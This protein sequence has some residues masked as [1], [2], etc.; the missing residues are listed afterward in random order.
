MTLSE[1]W[2]YLE[3]LMEQI[4]ERFPHWI[5][6]AVFDASKSPYHFWKE[7]EQDRKAHGHDEIPPQQGETP[8]GSSVGNETTRNGQRPQEAVP[9]GTKSSLNTDDPTIFIAKAAEIRSKLR[10]SLSKYHG[11]WTDFCPEDAYKDFGALIYDHAKG[12][13]S[14]WIGLDEIPDIELVNWN[15]KHGV[16]L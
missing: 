1:Y 13:K 7:N 16:F 3:D 4:R 6:L 9:D 8:P 14:W 10:K 5:W 11:K 15:A 2:D 12:C